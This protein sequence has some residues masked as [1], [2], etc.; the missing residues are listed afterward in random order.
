MRKLRKEDISL[1]YHLKHTVLSD[2]IEIE[3]QLSLQ[4]MPEVSRDTSHVYEADSYMLPKPTER[5]RG[6]VYL[7]SPYDVIEQSNSV[8]LYDYT[9]IVYDSLGNPLIDSEGNYVVVE[10]YEINPSEY[11]IDY[12]DGRVVTS[13]TCN[14]THITYKWNYV[15]LVDEWSA[16]EAADPPVVV[17][18]IHGTDKT[19]YQLG[20]GKL[21]TRKVDLH[22][23]ASNTAERNDI[24][25]TL[26]DGLYRKCC[27]VYDFPEGTILDTDGT[28]YGRRR[29]SN[30]TETLFSRTTVSGILGNLM[31]ENV[32][33]RHVSLPLLMTRGSSE[34]MLSDLNAYRSK[35]SFDMYHYTEY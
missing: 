28:W 23:F 5:G 9:K 12:I 15:S 3:E 29:N 22:V 16:V 17:I 19:G 32:T 8:G 10:G 21:A 27:P 11:M 25:E 7:D 14:P 31:F 20:G 24:V 13:G 26:Y 18:D 2:F 6:W 34:V 30:K 35:V 33:S 4:Y 1:Y